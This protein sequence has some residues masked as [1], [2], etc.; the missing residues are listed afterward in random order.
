MT[1]VFRWSWLLG[2]ALFFPVALPAGGGQLYQPKICRCFA[3][4]PLLAGNC[5]LLKASPSIFAPSLR[6]ISVG[7]PLR[8]LRSW[9]AADGKEWLQVNIATNQIMELSSGRRGWLNV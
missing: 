5:C 8:V 2:I 4:T 7:T 6:T 9:K 3:S 1:Y